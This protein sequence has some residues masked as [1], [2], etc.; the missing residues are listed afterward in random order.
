[1]NS[2]GARD[3]ARTMLRPA[4]QMA[5]VVDALN[6]RDFGGVESIYAPDALLYPRAAS[7]LEGR[8]AIRRFFEDWFAAY[9][10]FAFEVDE[11]RDLGSGVAFSAISQRG[12]LAGADAWVPK[13][14][15]A[16]VFTWAKGMIE[17]GTNF[18]DVD[19]GRAAAE[20]LA[21]ERAPRPTG[22]ALDELDRRLVEPV[23]LRK[24]RIV[25]T[26]H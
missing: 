17:M 26:S 16:L 1:M 23:P 20:R 9:E 13:E 4:E 7:V 21:G 5:R 3:P 11:F 10:E 8:E 18:T 24:N 14:R 22:R 2:A 25:A 12:R 19:E 6:A 15:S